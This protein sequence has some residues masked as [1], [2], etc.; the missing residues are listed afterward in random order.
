MPSSK[1]QFGDK[2]EKEAGEFLIANGYKILENNFRIKNL[3]E[4]DI[5]AEKN[6]KLIFFEVKTRDAKHESSFPIGFS[7][8][9]RKRRNLK[10]IGQLYLIERDIPQDRDWQ[11]DV[12]FVSVDF[13]NNSHRIEHLK[14]I[15]WEK[16][17]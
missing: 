3:G 2:G 14:N 17:Y 7:I 16:Y 13:E 11:V 6:G 8:N 10:R 4:L 1:R 15:L 9:E 12:I 5:V